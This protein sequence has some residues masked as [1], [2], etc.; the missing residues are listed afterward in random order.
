MASN[1]NFFKN[2][3]AKLK[4]WTFTYLRLLFSILL[5]SFR[6]HF[7][8]FCLMFTAFFFS[9]VSLSKDLL[10]LCLEQEPNAIEVTS[11]L[12]ILLKWTTGYLTPFH[13]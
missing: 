5:C 4:S 11:I 13:C 1:S 3:F 2:Y 8:Y 10:Q 7:H 9:S 12:S 6:R